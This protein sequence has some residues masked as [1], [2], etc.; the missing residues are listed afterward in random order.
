[1]PPA[2]A[3][4]F[5]HLA[6]FR[7]GAQRLRR[8]RERGC[9][10][11]AFASHFSSPDFMR[12]TISTLLRAMLAIMTCVAAADE[13]LT[14]VDGKPAALPGRG[15][16]KALALIFVAH[17]CPISNAYAPEIARLCKEFEP[18]GVAFRVVYAERDLPIADAAKHAREFA[19]P[20]PTVVDRDLRLSVRVG[21][22]MTPEAALLSPGGDVL[23]LGRIDDIYAD[24]GRRRAEA[25]SRDLRDAIEAVLA[26][27]QVKT[28]RTKSPGCHI[29]FGPA[30]PPEPK[31][32]SPE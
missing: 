28:P 27:R 12:L 25:T 21:A 29:F 1:M 22:K 7:N 18:R 14:G 16:C 3:D 30:Q 2:A 4:R 19:F 23:Y 6:I 20:C 5:G 15:E 9:L 24:Y 26:G 8:L 10:G 31:P 13:G 32:S 11:A 17:D